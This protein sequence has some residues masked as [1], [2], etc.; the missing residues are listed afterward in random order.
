M[1][2]DPEARKKYM[3]L[4]H[5]NPDEN[6]KQSTYEEKKAE[7]TEEGTPKWVQMVK[8]SISSTFYIQIF[9]TNIVFFLRTCN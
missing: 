6:A 5:H 7:Q 8:V 4:K 2:Y 1:V 3:E 9:R